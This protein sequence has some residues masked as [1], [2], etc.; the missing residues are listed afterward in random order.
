VPVKRVSVEL[1]RKTVLFQTEE[2]GDIEKV[3]GA[4]VGAGL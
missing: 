2:G 1:A 4:I 3:K